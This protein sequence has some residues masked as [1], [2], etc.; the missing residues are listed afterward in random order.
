M[1]PHRARDPELLRINVGANNGVPGKRAYHRLQFRTN[2]ENRVA[3][4]EPRTLDHT[5]CHRAHRNHL[6]EDDARFATWVIT[7]GHTHIE[8][9]PLPYDHLRCNSTHGAS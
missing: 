5:A 8:F 6:G 4:C 9:F 3:R 7:K 1:D 2:A